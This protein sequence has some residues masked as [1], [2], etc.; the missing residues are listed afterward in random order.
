ME[1][2]NFFSIAIPTY[3]YG[4]K[5]IEFLNFSFEKLFSQTFKDF[6]IVISDHSTDNTIKDLCE[7]WKDKLNIKHEFNERGR[8]IISP[9]INESMKRCTGKWIKILFQDDFL[10]DEESLQ[11]QFDFITK[12]E[13]LVWFV[14]MFYHSNDGINFYRLYHPFWHPHIYT[15]N[16]TMGCPSGITIKNEDLIF[17]DEEMNWLMDCDYYQRMFLK[18]GEPKVLNEITVVNRTWGE[19]L[20]DTTPQEVKDREYLMVVNKFG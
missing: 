8:G 6:E 17:F 18:H 9:N 4:G 7:Q 14:T 10:Y 1:S 11:K 20:T 13:N 15:G 5:G 2:N 19:R 12:T 16:N 3:G